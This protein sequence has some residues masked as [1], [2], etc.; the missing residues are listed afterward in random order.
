MNIPDCITQL[1]T[2]LDSLGDIR[3]AKSENEQVT[4]RRTY[5][6]VQR[7]ISGL[8]NEP[9][10]VADEQ[11]ALDA[12][13]ARSDA[14]LAKQKELEQA[15]AAAPDLATFTDT[16]ERDR[17]A[18]HVWT[19][20]QQLRLLH[21]GT[22]ILPGGVTLGSLDYIDQRIGELTQRR[23]RARLA[24]DAHLK[25]AEQLLGETVSS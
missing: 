17:A 23:D 21:A 12:W 9:K 11:A 18:D 7:V 19:A 1:K 5:D 24:L 25:Q 22:L 4:F 16:R 13:R 3:D 10:E 2:H 20:K 15:I 6:S 8:M 14:F